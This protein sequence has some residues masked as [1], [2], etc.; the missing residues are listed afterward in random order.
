MSRVGTMGMDDASQEARAKP[1]EFRFR[2]SRRGGPLHP[3]RLAE[4]AREKAAQKVATRGPTPYGWTVILYSDAGRVVRHTAVNATYEDAKE[5]LRV[6]QSW[7][8]PCDAWIVAK[9][10]PR[11]ST[12][13]P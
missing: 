10:V 3:E 2:R 1:P 4:L 11:Q 12:V 9:R 5:L 7:T 13:L 6:E 8:G